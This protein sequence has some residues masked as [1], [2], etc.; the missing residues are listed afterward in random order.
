M[1]IQITNTLKTNHSLEHNINISKR[2]SNICL[3]KIL[4]GRSCDHSK[5]L[6]VQKHSIVSKNSFTSYTVCEQGGDLLLHS[7]PRVDRPA[8]YQKS[9]VLLGLPE[10]VHSEVCI[11]PIWETKGM[12]S[13]FN[14]HS[15]KSRSTTA[16]SNN[17]VNLSKLIHRNAD[18]KLC[19][20]MPVWN[21]F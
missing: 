14:S 10:M 16:G 12:C 17:S 9:T 4:N 8:T 19:L 3:A 18:E 5:Y 15:P 13:T 1:I 2:I 21:G 6:R 20:M 7:Q 11:Q